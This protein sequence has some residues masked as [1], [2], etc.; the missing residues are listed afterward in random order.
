MNYYISKYNF[1]FLFIISKSSIFF[2]LILFFY[3]LFSLSND[4]FFFFCHFCSIKWLFFK[5]VGLVLFFMLLLSYHVVWFYRCLITTF[6]CYRL[7]VTSNLSPLCFSSSHCSALPVWGDSN[8]ISQIYHIMGFI[9]IYHVNVDFVS[10]LWFC[11]F[12]I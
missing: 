4:K 12:D 2:F 5:H 1:F 10:F 7:S 3:S 8:R 11:I 6:G 9:P